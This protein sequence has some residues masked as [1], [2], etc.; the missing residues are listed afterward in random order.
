VKLEEESLSQPVTISIALYGCLVTEQ[1]SREQRQQRRARLRT[2]PVVVVVR[3]RWPPLSQSQMVHCHL[4]CH[5][6]TAVP[7]YHL[8]RA[9][10]RPNVPFLTSSQ[11]S[12]QTGW[13][14]G[15]AVS[16]R[17]GLCPLPDTDSP[18]C[19]ANLYSRVTMVAEWL[20]CWT[21][22][23]KSTG[24]NRSRDAVE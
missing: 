13:K 1:R 9:S 15:S 8:H 19:S 18:A 21:Q 17:G 5:R 6:S 16:Y 22:A 14:L 7:W 10:R 24:S 4:R 12:H 2:S 23:W 20:A 11:A 3:A